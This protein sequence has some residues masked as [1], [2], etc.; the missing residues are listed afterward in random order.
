MPRG[1]HFPALE[2]PGALAE[3]IREFFR[4]LRQG[5][6]ASPPEEHSYPRRGRDDGSDTFELRVL[7]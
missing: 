3:E 5:G 1:G 4:P 6:T 2:A 7:W